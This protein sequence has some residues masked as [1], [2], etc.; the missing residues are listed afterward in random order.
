[1]AIKVNVRRN[2]EAGFKSRLRKHLTE[3]GAYDIPVSQEGIGG[4]NGDPDEVVCYKGRFIALECKTARGSLSYEQKQAK[5]AIEKAGG[6]WL[7]PIGVEEVDD[8]L[9]RIDRGEI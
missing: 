2:P 1:M 4:N 5:E 3:R 9:D 8:L 7:T 6:I